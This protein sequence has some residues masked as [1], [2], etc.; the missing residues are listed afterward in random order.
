MDNFVQ[1]F[2]WL[3]ITDEENEGTWLDTNEIQY[4]TLLFGPILTVM[5]TERA[6]PKSKWQVNIQANG[7]ILLEMT[8]L[9]LYAYEESPQ[10]SPTDISAPIWELHKLWNTSFI[11]TKITTRTATLSSLHPSSLTIMIILKIMPG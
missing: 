5:R 8:N 9:Q 3:G 2:A 1:N 11:S 7:N 6:M 10:I 4:Y